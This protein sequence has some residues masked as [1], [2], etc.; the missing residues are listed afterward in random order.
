MP[1]LCMYQSVSF[2]FRFVEELFI[3]PVDSADKLFFLMDDDVFLKLVDVFKDFVTALKIAWK[4]LLQSYYLRSVF[5]RLFLLMR[6]IL[7]FL[8][9]DFNPSFDPNRVLGITA[10]RLSQPHM[11]PVH[12]DSYLFFFFFLFNLSMHFSI[13]FFFLLFCIYNFGFKSG[14]LKVILQIDNLNLSHSSTIKNRI[15]INKNFRFI[16]LSF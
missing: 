13:A 1:F 8:Q 7:F 14:I 12:S 9:N 4:L 2:K 6:N 16:N 3:A 15:K 5:L 10:T 11:P